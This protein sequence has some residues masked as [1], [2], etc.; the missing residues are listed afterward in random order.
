MNLLVEYMYTLLPI[1]KQI[2]V[3]PVLSAAG[4]SGLTGQELVNTK[5]RILER[6]GERESDK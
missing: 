4:L 1:N 6:G 2:S 3:V 5:V